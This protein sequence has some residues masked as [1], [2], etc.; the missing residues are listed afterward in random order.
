MMTLR[1]LPFALVTLHLL[2]IRADNPCRFDNSK[3][4]ID[5]S[6]VGRSDGKAAFPDKTPPT[7]PDYSECIQCAV[8][9]RS[10][11]SS[12]EYSYNPCQPFTE[13]PACKNVAACQ[14]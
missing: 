14:G 11:R 8:G 7:S 3:G 10:L 5:L 12:L 6:T 1:I 4:V 2:L 13:E 9:L